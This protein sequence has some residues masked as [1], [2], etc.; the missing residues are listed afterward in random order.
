MTE[1]WE[2][3][4]SLMHSTPSIIYVYMETL[5]VLSKPESVVRESYSLQSVCK[6]DRKE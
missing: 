4:A 1:E 2:M 6:R 3:N 5:L